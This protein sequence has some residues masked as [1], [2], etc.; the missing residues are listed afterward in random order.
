MSKNVVLGML[1]L[2]LAAGS[3]G[4]TRLT[5]EQGGVPLVQG[6]QMSAN[7]ERRVSVRFVPGEIVVRHRPP[8]NVL[9]VAQ[10][11]PLGLERVDRPAEATV[12]YRIPQNTLAPMSE[13][14]RADRTLAAVEEM[15]KRPDVLFAQPNYLY[16]VVQ[17]PNDARFAE[18]W[19]YSAN[20]T[21]PGSAPGGIGLPAVWSTHK[22]SGTVVV[23]VLDTGILADHEDILGSPNRLPG[24]D[25]IS[26]P[27]IANDMGG[28]DSDATDAGDA[29]AA[30]ECGIGEPA[31][32]SSWHGTHVAGTVGVGG[33]NNKIG[34]AG[35]NWNVKVLP[36]RVL[37]KCGGS[38]MDI[39]DAI[40]WSAGL[41]VP[42]V[43]ANPTKAHVI[44]MSLGGVQR[45]TGLNGDPA[46]ESAIE[47]AF[48]ANVTVVVAAGNEAMDALQASPA[49]CSNTL[50]V[51]ASDLRGHFVSRYSNFGK[52]V[53]IMAPGGDVRRD[54]NNDKLPDGVLSMVQGGYAF[55]NGTSMAA[56]HVAGVAAL[57]RSCSPNLSAGNV[58]A[59]IQKAS[60]ARTAAHGCPAGHCGAGLLDAAAAMKLA[61]P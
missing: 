23:A 57:L 32:P 43:P 13:S 14:A 45:C 40:R 3:F 54:D 24:Y 59:I 61:C 34:I 15:R 50:T 51:A 8:L 2:A 19:H 55:F 12:L 7:L 6:N 48:K 18:Q 27:F 52:S 39:I 25:F 49:G 10:L 46:M 31:S 21:A 5:G 36:V 1:V 58:A 26:D 16:R 47:D 29:V 20:G 53:E 35:I 28:R 44:N 42:G 4:S 11:G 9:S 60:R 38:T 33:T 41:A 17:S 30:N 56:P 37:G 22:G